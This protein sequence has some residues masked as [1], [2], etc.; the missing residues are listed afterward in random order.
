[1]NITNEARDILK[2]LLEDRNK[3]G[4]RLFFAGFG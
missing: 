3:A 1:M 2:Q 4:I